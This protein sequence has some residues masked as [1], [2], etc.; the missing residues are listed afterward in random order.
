MSEAPK[1]PPT[2]SA[3]NFTTALALLR[4]DGSHFALTREFIPKT[5]A[6]VLQSHGTITPEDHTVLAQSFSLVQDMWG[7]F[8]VSFPFI[9]IEFVCLGLNLIVDSTVFGHDSS[10]STPAGPGGLSARHYRATSRYLDLDGCPPDDWSRVD[11]FSRKPQDDRR[12]RP[13]SDS[14]FEAIG[15]SGA[16]GGIKLRSAGI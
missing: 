2:T 16:P 12:E 7:F 14:V 6:S 1:V 9:L 13:S 11:I 8:E 3:L 15:K 4:E 10:E 5:V